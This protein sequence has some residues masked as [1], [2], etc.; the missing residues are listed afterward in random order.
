MQIKRTVPIFLLLFC[1]SHLFAETNTES[2]LKLI[3]IVEKKPVDQS[4]QRV[5]DQIIQYAIESKSVQI[6]VSPKLLPWFTRDTDYKLILFGSFIA[7]NIKPQ[8]IS[9]IKG[10][11]SYSGI[12]NLIK[13][14]EEIRKFNES[15]YMIEIDR[16]IELEKD[17]RLRDYTKTATQ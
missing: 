11:D 8:L 3:H 6:V 16:L 13:T 17:G 7:G 14:Y 4:S 5:Y 12:L 2:I 10:D 15:F 1:T 9:G